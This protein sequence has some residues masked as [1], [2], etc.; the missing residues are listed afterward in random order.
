MFQN[1]RGTMQRNRGKLLFA[2]AF[3]VACSKLSFGQTAP[4]PLAVS[5]ADNAWMLVS[6][7]LVLM[8]TGP[9]LALFYGGLVRKK[10]VLSVMMQSFAMMAIITILWAVVGYSL[11][12]RCRQQFYRRVAPCVPARCGAD[13]GRRLWLNDSV[14]DLY[15]LPTDVRNHYAST[16]HRSFCRAHEVQRDGGVPGVVVVDCLFSD[17]AH[18]VGQRRAA[19]CLAGRT[20]TYFGFCRRNG[21]AYYF[22]GV[23][24]G[25]CDLPGQAA[26]ISEGADASPLRRS[27]LYRGV[28][29]VGG[30]VWIQRWQCARS[31]DVGDQCFC[32]HAFCRCRRRPCLGR[33][34]KIPQWKAQRAGSD[35]PERWRAWLRLLQRRGLYIRCQR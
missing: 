18:G 12:L 28:F 6:A 17:G 19:E 11:R 2:V 23:C 5:N 35:F 9:G 32:E 10:N 16:D 22:R 29:V 15:G 34:R 30:L 31:G 27:E 4:A 26:W 25:V 20:T 14:A 1:F 13:A 21:G 33:V 7:A 3:G 8:M 24:V